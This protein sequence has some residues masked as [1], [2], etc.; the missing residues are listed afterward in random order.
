M[1][2]FGS[3]FYWIVF[4]SNSFKEAL[5]K[6][7]DPSRYEVGGGVS[8]TELTAEECRVQVSSW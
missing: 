5:F 7:A 6:G 2:W 1:I 8:W 3:R 4:F